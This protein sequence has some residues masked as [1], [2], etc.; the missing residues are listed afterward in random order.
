MSNIDFLAHN[1]ICSAVERAEMI[2]K[3][4]DVIAALTLDVLKGTTTAFDPDIHKLRPHVGQ[5][6]TA[7][8]LRVLLH[9]AEN[10]SQI[11][12]TVVLI[13]FI[14][15]CWIL[16]LFCQRVTVFA[17]EFKTLTRCAAFHK[18]TGL[19]TIQSVFAR[20]SLQQS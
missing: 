13:L 5:V 6:K 20:Q 3:Q 2:A 9:S 14:F 11:A 18:F 16:Q 4:A 1:R 10:P 19:C 7:E 15:F 8:R 17:V 12:G